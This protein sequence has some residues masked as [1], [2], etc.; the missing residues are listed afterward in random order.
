[1][2]LPPADCLAGDGQV[3]GVGVHLVRPRGGQLGQNFRQCRVVDR[4][5]GEDG[6]FRAPAAGPVGA[7]SPV[8]I[9]PHVVSEIR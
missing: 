5:D 8:S 6:R 7:G 1:M 9:H 4:G 2:A 3:D